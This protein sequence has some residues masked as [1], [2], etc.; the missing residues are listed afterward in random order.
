MPVAQKFVAGIVLIAL[1]TTAVLPGR[2]TAGVIDSVF[3][4]SSKL[5]GAAIAK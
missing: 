1:I 4:G 2:N 3:N 5:I